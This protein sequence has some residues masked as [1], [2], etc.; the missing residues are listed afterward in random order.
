M[1]SLSERL[2]TELAVAG[3][4]LVGF[5]DLG[6]LPS[7]QR[8]G[9]NY[10]IAIAVAIDPAVINGIGNGPTKDYYD[11]YFRLNKLLHDLD[12]K[13]SE[14]IKDGGF[15]AFPQTRA[16]VN[17]NYK[18]HSSMLPHKTVA[19]RAGLG[20]I[21]KCA[22]LV[23]EKYGSAV[24]ISSVLTDAPLDVNKPVN[25]SGCG[26]CNNCVRNCPA[27]ALSGDLW[28]AGMEREKFYNL[29]ACRKKA[30]ERAWKV[31]QGETHCGL[32]I[33]VC[34]KTRNY[35]KASGIDYGFPSVDMATKNDLEEILNLQ[36]LA[37]QENAIRYNDFGIPPLKQ[38]LDDLK[39]EAE[40]SIILKVVEDR[41]IVGSV[42][43]FEKDGSCYIGKLIVHPDYQNKGIGRKLM[44]AVEKCFKGLRFELFTGHLDEKNLAFYEKLGYKRFKEEKINDTLG[45]VYFEKG[46]K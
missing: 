29:L 33:L 35:I 30:L 21:G 46:G 19:T 25:E 3:A 8:Q 40:G 15:N 18:D 45:F 4:S 23:T 24:R 7:N 37:Y 44:V 11:E 1:D 43:A 6:E 26:S 13:A 12:L 5:A 9:F 42:R 2:K 34:P 17:I 27:E 41:R 36:K 10:G 20:W 28:S 32:C 14:I 31:S 16:K 38:T 22:L 39:K